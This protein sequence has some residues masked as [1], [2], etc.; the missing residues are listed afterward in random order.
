M[1]QCQQVPREAAKLLPVEMMRMMKLFGCSEGHVGKSWF[2]FCEFEK[3]PSRCTDF[4]VLDSSLHLLLVLFLLLVLTCS[5]L[6]LYPHMLSS[7]ALSVLGEASLKGFLPPNLELAVLR[8]GHRQN[9]CLMG[10]AC[11]SFKS[12]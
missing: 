8:L 6:G 4:H 3:D 7:T 5:A 9:D 10:C 2:K 1:S 12:S 11:K